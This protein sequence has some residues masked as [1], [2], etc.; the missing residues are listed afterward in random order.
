MRS[1]TLLFVVTMAWFPFLRAES[2][3]IEKRQE[4]K[5]E[6]LG[7]KTGP[8]EDDLKKGLVAVL[9]K[10]ADVQRAYLAIISMDGKKTWSVALCLA[11][12]K[13]DARLVQELGGVFRSIFGKDQFLD[14][15][16]L[17]GDA[18]SEVRKV[19]PAFYAKKNA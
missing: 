2:P 14:M 16:F 6:Y 18:E 9:E 12:K 11:S 8:V 3:P 19:C 1:L 7:E 4:A 15:M 13:S 5:I 17:T 10:N